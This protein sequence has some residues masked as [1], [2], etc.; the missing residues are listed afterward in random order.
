MD[1]V[2]LINDFSDKYFS[3]M[4][5]FPDRYVKRNFLINLFEG[6]LFIAGG[7]FISAQTVLPALVNR[8]G[9]GNLTIGALGVI[10]WIGLFIPQTFAARYAQAQPWK[11]R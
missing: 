5:E 7:S 3:L 9:G 1:S 10:V 11:K 6:A 2:Y 4:Q 8:L